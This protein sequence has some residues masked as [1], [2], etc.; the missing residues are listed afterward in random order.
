MSCAKQTVTATIV[1]PDGVRF[2]A[3]NHCYNPQEVCP[4]KDMPTGVGYELCK[5][6]C[7]QSGHAEVNAIRVAG[8]YAKG[9]TMYIEGHTYA[10][11]GCLD[12]IKEAGITSVV[13]SRP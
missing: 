9:A 8:S 5:S 4:R 7:N 10:C 6:V 3:T 1:T 13:F 2:R 12:A 11:D